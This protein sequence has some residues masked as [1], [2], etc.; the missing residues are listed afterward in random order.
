MKPIPKS[1]QEAHDF[2]ERWDPDGIFRESRERDLESFKAWWE[3]E[4]RWNWRM[5]WI[6]GPLIAAVLVAWACFMI[7]ETVR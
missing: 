5:K 3:A 6:G 4:Q 7:R 2:A 1:V